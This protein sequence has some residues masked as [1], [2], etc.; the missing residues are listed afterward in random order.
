MKRNQIEKKT[1]S[2]SCSELLTCGKLLRFYFFIK[3]YHLP[4]FLS[5]SGYALQYLG[6]ALQNAEFP[7]WF[8]H[9]N[10]AVL[11][12]LWSCQ[13]LSAVWGKKILQGVSLLSPK[14]LAKTLGF[15]LYASVSNRSS[16]VCP[17]LCWRSDTDLGPEKSLCG[18]LTL[19]VL[20]AS[21]PSL[22]LP[23]EE[24]AEHHSSFF[25]LYP[26]VCF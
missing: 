17:G 21:T 20:T 2:V 14:V 15:I 25:S 22:L 11:F 26:F 3:A 7:L 10:L 24:L 12:P 9:W 23:I 19:M 18:W 4:V 8:C 16:S 6:E 5:I 1:M 13:T